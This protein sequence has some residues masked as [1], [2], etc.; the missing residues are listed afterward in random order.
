M[1]ALA[2]L[3]GTLDEH[4]HHFRRYEKAELEEKVRD[5]GFALEDCRFLNRPGILGWYVNGKILRRRVLPSGQLAAFRLMLPLL[6]REEK[7]PP[8][9][10]DVAARDRAQGPV[11]ADAGEPSGFTRGRALLVFLLVLAVRLSIAGQFRGNYD[12]ESFRIVADLVLSGQNLYA[13]TTRYNYSPVWACTVAVLWAVARPNFP[14]FVLLIGLLQTAADVAAALLVVRIARRLGR[15]AGDARRAGLLF[16]ANPISVLVSGA[17]GQF[18]GIAILLLLGAILVAL[19]DG[20]ERRKGRV[21]ALLSASLLVK[22]VTAFHPLLF[23]RRLRRPGLPDAAVATPYAVLGLSFVPFLGAWRSIWENVGVYGTRGAKPGAMLATIDIPRYGAVVYLAFF[24]AAVVWAV[25]ESRGLE[26]PR[27]TLILWLAVLTFLPS[28]GI[29]YLVWPLAVG[30]LYPS[31]GLGL[32]TLAGALF[33]SAWS[34]ELEWPLRASS[35]A[36][37]VAGLVW[38]ITETARARADRLKARRLPETPSTP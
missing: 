2:R 8:G 4:L 18:D 22:H 21:V 1:P 3:Y 9:H 34:L 5:A 31:I 19:G 15:S 27:A 25:R 12:S 36:T 35:L 20:L 37:W 33:H 16:F 32:F 38:L 23:S 29:Q 7:N 11:T 30:A 17:H 26:L 6:K 10:G 24:A 13:A 28:Y 14:F